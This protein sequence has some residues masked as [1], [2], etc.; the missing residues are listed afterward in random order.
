MALLSITHTCTV[1]RVRQLFYVEGAMADDQASEIFKERLKK[2]REMRGYN[3]TELANRAKLPPS[4]V[5]HFEAGPRKPSFENLK[6]LAMALNV[7]TDYLLGR[8]DSPEASA[9]VGRLHRD[10]N[11]LSADDLKLTEEFVEMLVRR[12]QSIEKK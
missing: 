7:T 3:Q 9:P 5:S 2:A 11:K 4:S 10:I 1:V 8:V 6:R 12:G